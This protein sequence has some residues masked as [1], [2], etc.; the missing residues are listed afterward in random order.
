MLKFLYEQ[1]DETV[2]Q[3]ITYN[4]YLKQNHAKGKLL[5]YKLTPIIP[6]SD[7]FPIGEYSDKIIFLSMLGNIYNKQ[8]K[9]I[10]VVS[11]DNLNKRE[12]LSTVGYMPCGVMFRTLIDI[13]VPFLPT[14]TI[15]EHSADFSQFRV[16]EVL[17]GSV[18]SL[19]YTEF[20]F[21]ITQPYFDNCLGSLPTYRLY[22]R[23]TVPKGDKHKAFDE[24][25]ASYSRYLK[26]SVGLKKLGSSHPTATKDNMQLIG[27]LDA[28][29]GRRYLFEDFKAQFKTLGTHSTYQSKIRRV[30]RDFSVL[31]KM[32]YS[33][34]DI[35]KVGIG[36]YIQPL[37]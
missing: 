2:L 37:K 18:V 27:F 22:V 15:D 34:E 8:T 35:P 26:S 13:E 23:R 31:S 3:T 4:L 25:V 5:D 21:F 14:A 24:Q 7:D 33:S 30:D 36:R 19:T 32:V 29:D 12:Q 17:A 11:S 1:V 9:T 6:I 16:R 20:T 10:S 28:S